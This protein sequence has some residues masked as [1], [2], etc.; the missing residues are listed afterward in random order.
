MQIQKEISSDLFTPLP[1]SGMTLIPGFKL[2]T[3]LV[4]LKTK[5][6]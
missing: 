2:P 1:Y 4:M 3:L 5:V 6:K